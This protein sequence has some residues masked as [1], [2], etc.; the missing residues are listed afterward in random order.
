MNYKHLSLAIGGFS[1]LLILL[2]AIYSGHS[3]GEVARIISERDS[4]R[5]INDR[6]T[7]RMTNLDN[8]LMVINTSIDSINRRENLLFID[9]RGESI[10]TTAEAKRNVDR[11]ADLIDKQKQRII[12]L[13][14]R[15]QEAEEMDGPDQNLTKVIAYYKNL[16]AAKDAE[17][18]DLK[19][20]LNQKDI[21]IDQLQ[22][23]IGVQ[24]KTIA[25]LDKKTTM[26]NEAL[27]RQDAMLNQCYMRIGDK[28]ALERDGIIKKGKMVTQNSLDRSKFPKVDIRAFTEIEFE[29]RKPRIMTVMPQT[30]YVITTN[31]NGHYT[32]R[33]SNPTEF[34][35]VSNFLVI[36]TN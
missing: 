5:I 12:E 18:A 3:T 33:I 27:K 6:Q 23:K 32:L 29:A 26:Q 7:R 25:E 17:I 21:S 35:S 20:Q 19:E 9:E 22:S 14:K 31:G 36:Q 10:S 1:L 13:E 2:F 15:L 24:E 11:L 30:S 4:L 16:I 28:Q 34:W 8:L